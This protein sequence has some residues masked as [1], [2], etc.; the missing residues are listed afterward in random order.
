MRI[1]RLLR[2]PVT[3]GVLALG[4][5][6][7]GVAL[8][9]FQPWRLFTTVEVNE[10]LPTVVVT[11]GPEPT[12]VGDT[13][14]EPAKAPRE[15]KSLAKG[16]FISHEHETRGEVRVLELPDG[17]R[18]LRIEDLN[19]SDGPDLRVRLSDQPVKEGR[20]G[21]FNLDDGKHLELGELKG[22]RGNANYAIP[23]GAD[24]DGLKTVTIWCKR[25]GVSFGAAAL[26]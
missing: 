22:N 23:A 3:W 21:W 19:T 25:F 18:V 14:S 13:A 17:S 24:L 7:F 12:S 15:P 4:A 16:T 8:Y 2:H 10:A 11:S 20:A 6:A 5:V 1:K 9:L 26:T